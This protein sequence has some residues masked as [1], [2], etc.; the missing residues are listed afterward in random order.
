MPFRTNAS[1]HAQTHT[2]NFSYLHTYI[3]TTKKLMKSWG[4]SAR[5]LGG[6]PLTAPQSGLGLSLALAPALPGA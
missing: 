1:C 6:L 2:Q 3:I 5:A 4:A